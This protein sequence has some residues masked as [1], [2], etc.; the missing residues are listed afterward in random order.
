MQTHTEMTSSPEKSINYQPSTANES[1]PAALAQKD[2]SCI[3]FAKEEQPSTID[4]AGLSRLVAPEQNTGEGAANHQLS[5]INQPPSQNGT[6]V[7]PPSTSG[8]PT[9][10]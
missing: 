4:Q 3:A 10:P 2:L 8:L 5:T 6:V 9:L 7:N 1:S